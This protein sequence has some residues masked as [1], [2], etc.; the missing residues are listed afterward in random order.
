MREALLA[1]VLAY[2]SLGST[3]V[4][5]DAPAPTDVPVTKTDEPHRIP[6]ITQ[7]LVGAVALASAALG[8]ALVVESR[9]L[10]HEQAVGGDGVSCRPCESSDLAGIRTQDYLGIGFLAVGGVL[11]V[12][13]VALIALDATS[14]KKSEAAQ[15]TARRQLSLAVRF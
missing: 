2:G 3:L 7:G 11:L 4:R 8:V 13:D 15:L 6:V 12:A 14:R 1:V 5:A 10:F 9:V